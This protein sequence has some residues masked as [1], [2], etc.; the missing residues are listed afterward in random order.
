MYSGG[1][2]FAH[3]QSWAEMQ[4]KWFAL[5][6]LRDYYRIDMAINFETDSRRYPLAEYAS[7]I[8]REQR[9]SSLSI[10]RGDNTSATSRKPWDKIKPFLPTTKMMKY[11]GLIL[12]RQH[13]ELVVSLK[14]CSF[15]F[16][17]VAIMYHDILLN[18]SFE[19]CCGFAHDVHN[20]FEID[21]MFT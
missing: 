19:C 10:N 2:I 9:S 11:P 15:Y 12:S 21:C 13:S 17:V 7:A 1:I 20:V 18:P 16:S 8:T 6:L 14:T 4:S 5:S 3:P